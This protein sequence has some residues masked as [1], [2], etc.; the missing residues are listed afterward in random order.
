LSDAEQKKAKSQLGDAEVSFAV[1]PS[2]LGG[3]VV[4]SADKVIDGSVKSNLNE[5]AG[6]LN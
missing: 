2:I 3:I 5:L 4:R 1:D 6:S